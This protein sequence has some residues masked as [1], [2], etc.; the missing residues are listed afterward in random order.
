MAG[1][2]RYHEDKNVVK[3]TDHSLLVAATRYPRGSEDQLTE[4]VACA[5]RR[6]QP[7]AHKL[8]EMVQST[9]SHAL[10]GLERA[11]DFRV[12]T[13]VRAGPRRVDFE[14]VLCSDGTPLGRLWVESKV[15]A[16]YGE[17][18]LPDYVKALER[19]QPWPN[20]V[21]ATIVPE[22]RKR[23]AEAHTEAPEVS[24]LTWEEIDAEVHDM[25]GRAGRTAGPEASGY[26]FVLEE[27]AHYLKWRGLEMVEPLKAEDVDVCNSFNDVQ[28][29]LEKLLDAVAAEINATRRGLKLQ[30][31]QV[32]EWADPDS[33][34][35]PDA[36]PEVRLF[37]PG[38]PEPVDGFSD[39]AV[40][41][42]GWVWN[43]RDITNEDTWN[44]LDRLDPS[45][46]GFSKVDHRHGATVGVLWLAGA[47]RLNELVEEGDEFQ[48]QVR[49]LTEWA[50]GSIKRIAEEGPWT[51]SSA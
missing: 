10:P 28:R 49:V 30:G 31:L 40:F 29:R 24:V 13:Q 16:P 21:L 38:E 35:I 7:L 22:R 27:L 5:L 32:S 9:D 4:I 19:E 50:T 6:C 37:L 33:W 34:V 25:L 1:I 41:L 20:G 12:N 36:Y 17:R 2:D 51:G 39:D 8:C 26:R 18:Q 23:K 47:K 14:V 42:A 44:R 46:G 3:A 15:D 43:M 48:D 45:P 11:N